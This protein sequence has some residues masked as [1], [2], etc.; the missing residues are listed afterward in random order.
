MNNR[1]TLV[2]V[3][4]VVFGLV[5][6][7]ALLLNALV[8]ATVFNVKRKSRTPFDYVKFSLAVADILWGMFY[9]INEFH[10]STYH[11]FFWIKGILVI[12]YIVPNI[13]ITL[14]SAPKEMLGF[15]ALAFNSPVLFVNTM[16]IAACQL[17]SLF[18]IA[19][20][21]IQRFL[22]IM[23][24]NWFRK[25]GKVFTFSSLGIVWTLN[26]VNMFL[27]GNELLNNTCNA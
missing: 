18:H 4:G 20:F 16:L 12:G 19:F 13:A 2:T 17:S 7:F 10:V 11:H 27:Q 25:W 15:G 9:I 6:C 5:G 23:F 22:A 8:I 1:G 26:L 3:F 24:S 14:R 21:A